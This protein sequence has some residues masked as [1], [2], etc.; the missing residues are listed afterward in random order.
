[1]YQKPRYVLNALAVAFGPSA[2]SVPV[3]RLIG[4]FGPVGRLIG[5]FGPAG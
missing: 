5:P 2:D 3:G 4:P 1:M